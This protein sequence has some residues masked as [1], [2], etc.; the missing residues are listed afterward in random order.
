VRDRLLHDHVPSGLPVY[1][2]PGD[3]EGGLSATGGLDNFTSVTG[4]PTRQVFDHNGTLFVLL[5]SHTASLRT[6][7]WDQVPLLRS[8]L[9]KAAADRT[10][11]ATRTP[12]R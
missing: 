2:V 5:D 8:E 1:W 6:S 4:R 10:V 7:D 9:R 11:P 12:P 3:H